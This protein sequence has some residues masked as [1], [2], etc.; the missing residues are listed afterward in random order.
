MAFQTNEI[1]MRKMSNAVFQD[2]INQSNQN[3]WDFRI[4]SAAHSVP[5]DA[6]KFGFRMIDSGLDGKR[7]SQ[8][9][10]EEF[11]IPFQYV[12][13]F[14]VWSKS[15]N[16]SSISDVIGRY[17][18]LSVYGNSGALDSMT[19][20]LNYIA[21]KATNNP[22]Q[23]AWSV[24]YVDQIEKRLQSLVFPQLDSYFS[25]PY[26]VLL[27]IGQMFVDFPCVIKAI[28]IPRDVATGNFYWKTGNT[29]F[30][31]ITLELRSSYPAWQALSAKGIRTTREGNKVFARKEYKRVNAVRG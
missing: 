20:T 2:M 13:E 16:W 3:N 21:E 28:T 6:N 1:Q 5:I 22:N 18:D 24:S 26:K 12:E 9:K 17:E 15:A 27:N 23:K 14:P 7:D 31:K 30:K 8:K 19:L 10:H 25:P 4:M 11:L 29:Y